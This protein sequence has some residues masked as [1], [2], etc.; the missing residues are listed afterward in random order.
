MKDAIDLAQKLSTF[1]DHWSPRTVAQFNACDVMVVKVQGE[2]V[3][4][5]HDDTDD[6]F[7]VLKGVLDIE[8]RDVTV[9][10]RQ[11]QMYIVPKG[12]EHRPVAREEVHLLLIEPTG[13]PNTGNAETAAPRKVV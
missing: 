11:G 6:F 4:H 3:W 13:T 7:L 5:K 8:M 1:S 9:T 12:V 2:F 10:L